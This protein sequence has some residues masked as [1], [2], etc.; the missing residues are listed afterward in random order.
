MHGAEQASG[1]EPACRAPVAEPVE[2]PE[3]LREELHEARAAL[4][5]ERAKVA[6]MGRQLAELRHDLANREHALQAI[7]AAAELREEQLA[8]RLAR[9]EESGRGRALDLLAIA[10]ALDAAID[11][12]APLV[13]GPRRR[14]LREQLRD[15]A[16][17]LAERLH[18]FGDDLGAVAPPEPGGVLRDGDRGLAWPA[19]LAA[20]PTVPD[21]PWPGVAAAPPAA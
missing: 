21:D 16:R 6:A 17:R 15:G 8:A 12:A 20:G 10:E 1:P 3:R 9:A 14:P 13:H 11:A 7:Q 5:A 19:D 4:A 2:T 18:R